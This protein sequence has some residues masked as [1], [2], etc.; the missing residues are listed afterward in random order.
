MLLVIIE[1]VCASIILSELPCPNECSLL[2]ANRTS[3]DGNKVPQMQQRSKVG[4]RPQFALKCGLEIGDGTP[5]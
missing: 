3:I 1:E 5:T 2:N 4:R